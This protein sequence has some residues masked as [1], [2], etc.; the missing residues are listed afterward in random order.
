MTPPSIDHPYASPYE[1]EADTKIKALKS[2]K[3]SQLQ[4]CNQESK[5]QVPRPR[6]ADP[7]TPDASSPWSEF[8][9]PDPAFTGS[10]TTGARL[11]DQNMGH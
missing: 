6:N 9:R 11:I 5:Q 1:Q 4:R 3:V 2:R 7:L 8:R 10:Q